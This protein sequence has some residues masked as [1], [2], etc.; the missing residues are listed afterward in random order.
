MKKRSKKSTKRDAPVMQEKP[1]SRLTVRYSEID[2]EALLTTEEV[3]QWLGI[4]ERSVLYLLARGLLASTYATAQR[5]RVQAKHVRDYIERRS[6]AGV[7]EKMNA[8]ESRGR[9]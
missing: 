9:K 1:Q 3:M 2:D 5:R 6:N 7:V 4:S 8:R